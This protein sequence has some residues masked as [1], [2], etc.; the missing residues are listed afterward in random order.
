MK[1]PEPAGTRRRASASAGKKRP[2]WLKVSV[3]ELQGI[4]HGRT[5]WNDAGSAI[6]SLVIHGWPDWFPVGSPTVTQ[7]RKCRSTGAEVNAPP[8]S[9]VVRMCSP[10]VPPALE[11]V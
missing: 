1:L 8:S 3:S 9:E 11:T 2:S 6:G 10:L 4:S 7:T 5:Y